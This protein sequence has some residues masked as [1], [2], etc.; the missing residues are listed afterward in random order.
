MKRPGINILY[1]KSPINMT[2]YHYPLCFIAQRE[3]PV[4][5]LDISYCLFSLYACFLLCVP[6][7]LYCSR[8]G[9]LKQQLVFAY[10]REK[11]HIFYSLCIL[12]STT[13]QWQTYKGYSPKCLNECSFS[14]KRNLFLVI[15]YIVI[16]SAEWPPYL[17]AASMLFSNNLNP[18][19][20]KQ[21]F[22]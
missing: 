5:I 9:V 22:F 1:C 19:S 4:F 17:T 6:F 21:S 12:H 15:P 8:Y 14:K 2:Y 3:G 11:N 16:S 18:S 10:F 7:P 20:Y 13:K